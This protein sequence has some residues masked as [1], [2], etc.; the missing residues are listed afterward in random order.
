MPREAGSGLAVAVASR[1]CHESPPSVLLYIQPDSSRSFVV[2]KALMRTL[3][4]LGLPV[5]SEE[6]F[7][8][9]APEEELL[10][11][12]SLWSMTSDGEMLQPVVAPSVA[13]SELYCCPKTH[14]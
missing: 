1:D 10:L 12:N 4:R 8:F 14:L 3:N 9:N 2:P 5:G 6:H 13:T 7:W 11:D